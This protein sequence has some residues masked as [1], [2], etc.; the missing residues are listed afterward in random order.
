MKIEFLATFIT[1]ICIRL[2]KR[3]E[4]LTMPKLHKVNFII[5]F[6]FKNARKKLSDLMQKKKHKV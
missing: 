5:Y 2:H 4:E 6:N 3:S 1:T